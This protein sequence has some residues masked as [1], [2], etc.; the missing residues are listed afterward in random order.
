MCNLSGQGDEF[1]EGEGWEVL[2]LAEQQGE[3]V[4]EDLAEPA[5]QEVPCVACPDFLGVVALGE[6]PD[7]RLDAPSLV[8]QPLRPGLPLARGV[9]EGREQADAPLAQAHFGG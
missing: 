8:G 4:A 1:G 3:R 5:A 2:P 9:L 6:L 7:A